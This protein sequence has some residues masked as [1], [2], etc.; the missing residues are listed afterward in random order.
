[1]AF[2]LSYDLLCTDPRRFAVHSTM[3]GIGWLFRLFARRADF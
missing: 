2:K 3:G 1:M